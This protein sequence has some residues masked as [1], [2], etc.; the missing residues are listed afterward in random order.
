MN[1]G[2]SDPYEQGICPEGWHIPTDEEWTQL[3]TFL[4][5]DS[6]AGG[7]MKETGFAH[8][9]TPNTGATNTS[10]FTGLGH[11]AQEYTDVFEPSPHTEYYFGSF[12]YAY[13]WSSTPGTELNKFIYWTLYHDRDDFIR[14]E[15]HG[16]A[17]RSVRC[18]K[19]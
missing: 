19:N 17:G 6:V 9:H 3:A 7:K 10:G 13:F 8:W 12:D 2:D 4:G 1:W 11:G 16:G 18:L 15:T 14:C 5:G